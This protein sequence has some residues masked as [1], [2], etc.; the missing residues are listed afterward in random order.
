M[1]TDT[2]NT[3]RTYG[4][5]IAGRADEPTRSPIE[6]A[7][8]ATGAL[9]ASYSDG[10]GED[11]ARAIEAARAAFEQGP[12]PGLP[13][14]EKARILNRWADAIERETAR[15][16]EIEIEEVGKPRKQARG[17]IEG[18]IGHF[19][20]AASLAA[21][22][23]G[24][25]Y[26][27]L[28]GDYA[29]LVVREPVGVVAMI[30]AWNF[31]AFIFA[32][33][34]PY[35]IAAGCSVVLKPSEWTS[36]TA[37]EMARLGHE[38]GLPD[39]LLNVVTGYG[40]TVGQALVHSPD[41]DLV[42]F[43]GSTATGAAVL[44]GQKVNFKRVALEMGGKGATVVFP[45]ADLEEAVE[46]VLFGAFFNAGQECGS[47][48]RLLVHQDIADAFVDRV[49]AR[50]K[51]LV[52]GDPF[53]EETDIGPLIHPVHMDKVTSY[54]ERGATE[55]AT[56]R[57][58]G[59]SL[60]GDAL[61]VTPAVFDDVTPGTSLFT[62]EVFGP[63]LTVTRF[64]SI[65]EAIA[66][67]NDTSYGLT[68]SVWSKNVD[69]AMRVARALRSGTVWINTTV[70]GSPQLPYGGY[71]SSGQGREMGIA[72]LEEFTEV[73]SIHLRTGPRP[74]FFSAP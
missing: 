38:A 62:D 70:D 36:G 12:W 17:D 21:T 3:T 59:V 50:T 31:P 15:L 64:G 5:F 57:C 20:Y 27:N 4:H 73:K 9:V 24:D 55:G 10:T 18:A 6:R 28:G 30:I 45:D 53:D 68:N 52:V 8:P 29:G 65:E 41:V 47:G 46:G 51:Q 39:A 63:L 16:T 44:D 74:R 71:K 23:R 32:Q 40:T 54:L 11:A 58:G 33:K 26:T 60:D 56:L 49:V 1:S 34:V 2:A 69:T 35:A 66:L 42:S 14:L 43:T 48:P 22:A 61:F 72:G 37:L 13:G 67:A 7:S 25:A 19:R